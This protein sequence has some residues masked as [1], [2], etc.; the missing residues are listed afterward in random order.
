ML[1]LYKQEIKLQKEKREHKNIT[2]NYSGNAVME[3]HFL[4][5][6]DILSNKAK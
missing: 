5:K 3:S 4:L 6:I 2:T 1:I